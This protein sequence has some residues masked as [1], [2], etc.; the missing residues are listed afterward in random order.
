MFVFN[1]ASTMHYLCICNSSRQQSS[2]ATLYMK[3][4]LGVLLV[5]LLIVFVYL[6]YYLLKVVAASL[7]QTD[8]VVILA[9]VQASQ[10]SSSS[11][12]S[13]IT[14]ECGNT[15]QVLYAKAHFLRKGVVLE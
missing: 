13:D 5:I 4:E 8:L 1:S 6:L 15:I 3:L 9:L 11:S 7:K 10:I 12:V 14:C 2:Y